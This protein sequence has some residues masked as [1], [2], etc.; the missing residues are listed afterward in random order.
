MSHHY[1]GPD[2]GFPNGD[3]RLDLCDLFAFPKPGDA[4]RSV[5]IMDVHPSAGVNP[6]GP[7]STEPF[8]S[9]AIYELRIDTDGDAVANVAYRVRF[10]PSGNGTTTAVVRRVEGADAAGSG[11]SG[12]VIIADAPVSIGQ[13]ARV[14]EAGEYRFFA[15]WRSDPFFFDAGGALNNFQFTGDD[16]F[17]DKD[18]CSIVLEM[19]NSALGSSRVGLWFRVLIPAGSADGND[20][21]DGGSWVQVDRG[22]HTQQVPIICPNEEKAAYV[23]SEPV[24]DSRFLDSFAH[25][26]Q[27]VGGYSSEQAKQ[28]AGTLLPDILPYDPALPVAYPRNGRALTDDVA[29]ATFT[30]LTN[31]KITEDKVG[32]HTDFLSDF[33]YLGPPHTAYGA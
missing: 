22:A 1:S 11:N 6:P 21:T 20:G 19:P 32:P 24:D 13:D 17:A 9:E 14:V 26:L 7:T 12:E 15:G 18:V 30:V 5:L 27:Q 25:V 2:F 4:S 3:A 16:F 29:D 10:A 33:P 31:G 8:A 28:V 23:S